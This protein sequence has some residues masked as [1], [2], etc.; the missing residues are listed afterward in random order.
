MGC[1]AHKVLRREAPGG[2]IGGGERVETTVLDRESLGAFRQAFP[3]HLDAD[4]FE[5]GSL[6]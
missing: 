5:L 3:A 1:I 4:P 2:L 6:Q